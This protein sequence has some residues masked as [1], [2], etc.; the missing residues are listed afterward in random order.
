[1]KLVDDR[2]IEQASHAFMCIYSCVMGNSIPSF[3]TCSRF[4]KMAEKTSAVAFGNTNRVRALT[5][6]NALRNA[7]VLVSMQGCS[8]KENLEILDDKIS[9]L[10]EGTQFWQ[11]LRGPGL[12]AILECLHVR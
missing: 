6:S 5:R 4:E 12:R 8:L 10:A 9:K 2:S 11:H 3:P 7:N 1:M